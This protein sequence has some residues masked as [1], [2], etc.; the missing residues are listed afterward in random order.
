M[1]GLSDIT[2][3]WR[4]PRCECEAG[5][6]MVDNAG[7]PTEECKETNQCVKTICSCP[8]SAGEL[9]YQEGECDTYEEYLGLETNPNPLTCF[10]DGIDCVP[11]SYIRGG[12]W[13]HNVR[14]DLFSNYYNVQYGWGIEAVES[15]GQ[16]VNTLRS[17][18][19]EMEAYTYVRP[20]EDGGLA[21]C[22]YTNAIG[23]GQGIPPYTGENF[24]PDWTNAMDYALDC[25]HR[26]H[27]LDYN[28]NWA[29]IYNTEQVS[30]NLHLNMSPK[31][32]APEIN[33]F[34]QSF[35][36]LADPLNSRHE[37]LFEKVEQKYRF[38][39]FWDSTYNRGEVIAPAGNF[40]SGGIGVVTYPLR[41][42]LDG[43]TQWL[44]PQNI[45]Y[46]KDPL[47]RKKFRH[48]WNKLY[49]ER[50][51]IPFD[52]LDT[53]NFLNPDS[54]WAYWDKYENAVHAERIKMLL[55]LD[56]AKI[57]VSFR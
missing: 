43:Y 56:N 3:E 27:V 29:Y 37:I 35:E 50:R 57:N 49:L 11:S 54:P 34:P 46:F 25:K 40:D 4:E 33:N 44:N 30:G 19:Y 15:V 47:Q 45:D 5:Y 41:T 55:K 52:D 36:D 20:S 51:P 18:E 17:I 7:L 21:I 38:N 39:Q 23:G 6:Q 16:T 9:I 2:V 48:Y 22:G 26:H 10:Y 13:R 42:D 14:C 12:L 1:D 32:N 28:F 24:P 53:W 31:N 8:P